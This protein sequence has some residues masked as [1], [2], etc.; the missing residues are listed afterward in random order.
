MSRSPAVR[1]ED[2]PISIGVPSL[3]E[4]LG[5]GFTRHRF[6]MLQ[7]VPGSGKTTLALQF[8]MEGARR[9]DSVLY[10][11]LSETEEEIRAI[12]VS[13]G[14]TLDGVQVL[15]VVP[16]EHALSPE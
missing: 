15:E 12:A 11:T 3:D 8:L 16:S 6:Y 13:H 5:G 2:E 7:G 10:V 14:W 4:I 1:H 9:G